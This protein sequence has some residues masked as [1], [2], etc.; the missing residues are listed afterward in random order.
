MKN[1]VV[2]T[3]AAALMAAM[4]A[5]PALAQDEG[6]LNPS[7][8]RARLQ[9]AQAQPLPQVAQAPKT[10]PFVTAGPRVDLSIEEAVARAR[11]KNIDIGVAR[12]TP[13]L[14]DFTIA[15][16]EANYRPNLTSA[17]SDASVTNF[18]TNITQGIT[19]P[20]A[21]G[22]YAWQGGLAQNLWWGGGNYTVGFTNSRTNSPST[23][24][25]RNPNFDSRLTATLVQPLL[26]GFQIDSTRASLQTNRISQQNDEISLQTT[27]QTTIANTRNAYWDLVYAIQAVEAAQ[28]SL[29]IADTLV[30]QNQQRV[31]IGT[32][33]PIDIK[34]AQ[35]ESANRRLTL[36]QAQATVRT[37]ELALKRLIVTGTDDPLW[38]SSINPVDRPAATAEP[39]DVQAATA[40]ALRERTDLQQSI[41][42]LKI[43]DINLR[44]QVDQ[45]R[46]QLNLT[47]TYGLRGVGGPFIQKTGVVDP[48]TGV[49]TSVSTVV[50]SGYLDALRNIAGFDGPQWTLGF[51]FAYPLGVSAQESTVA[52]SKLSLEQSQANLKALQLQIATD[53]ANAA[54][55]VQS[56]LESV[57]ASTTA[58]ELAKEKLDATQSK[59]DV[60]MATNYEVVQA[61]R[62]F[63][64]AQNNELRAIANYRKAL[65]N[66]EAVQTVGTRGVSAG[67]TGTGTTTGTTSGTTTGSTTGG[68]TTGGGGGGL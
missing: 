5:V 31:E 48:L 49:T 24:A 53:V 11:E 6:M 68:S 35:A 40:R 42:N 26:R 30:Q 28:N 36:V 58:R 51:N 55:T 38:G 39:I 29:D 16:L 20:T 25:T 66:Y 18:P 3:A 46:P 65:V 64:D 61:Q 52:R 14:T 45:T 33:A 7:R 21:T 13:R 15:G 60:G 41:N 63:A 44:N 62:D 12:I 50:P 2:V 43:S 34:S 54:L 23:T 17:F 37:T 59:L 22:T 27:I 47:A 67:V 8:V 19:A 10:A 32:L 9:Q 56:S 4:A 57:Q 1:N